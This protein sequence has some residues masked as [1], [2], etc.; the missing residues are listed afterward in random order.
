MPRKILA[1]DF[2]SST[3]SEG[4]C[5]VYVFPCV[6]EDLLKLGFSRDPLSRLQSLH[7]RWFE[8]FDIER[9][10]LIET[11]TVRDARGLELALGRGIGQHGAVEPLTIRRDAAGTTEW[12]R[13][14]YAALD[15]EAETLRERGFVVHRPA[16]AWLRERLLARSDRLF[17]WSRESL[18]A[19]EQA[20]HVGER[21]TALERDLRDTL[22]AYT[23]LAIDLEPWL[24]AAVWDWYRPGAQPPSS[25]ATPR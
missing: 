8:F 7:R 15:R 25:K 9:A 4:Q 1:A 3:L 19:A 21:A 14:A 18:A 24:P 2:G 17:S 5:F 22:D 13:G 10:V 12:Y 6:W 16:R 11:E 23:A 20:I